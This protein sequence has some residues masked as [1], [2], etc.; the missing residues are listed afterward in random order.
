MFLYLRL[1]INIFVITCFCNFLHKPN[2]PILI[3]LLQPLL[4]YF[5]NKVS[6]SASFISSSGDIIPVKSCFVYLFF[7]G[8]P[9]CALAL[10]GFIFPRWVHFKDLLAMLSLFRRSSWPIFYSW[11]QPLY[12]LFPFSELIPCCLSKHAIFNPRYSF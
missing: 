2:L 4:K 9:S 10:P 1:N 3:Y 6:P 5:N 8:P 12:R 11:S 7:Y